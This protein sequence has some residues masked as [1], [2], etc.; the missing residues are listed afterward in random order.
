VRRLILLK[1]PHSEDF[2]R[3]VHRLLPVKNKSSDLSETIDLSGQRLGLHIGVGKEQLSS[4]AR[5]R[6]LILGVMVYMRTKSRNALAPG[7]VIATLRV[8]PMRSITETSG[9]PGRPDGSPAALVNVT[10]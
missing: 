5:L 9:M 10:L 2:V 1:E 6:E 7:D 4:C 3:Y 8:S